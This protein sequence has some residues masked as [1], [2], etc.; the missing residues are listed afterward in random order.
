MSVTLKTKPKSSTWKKCL[1]SSAVLASVQE[2]LNFW[3]VKELDTFEANDKKADVTV[4]VRDEE[5]GKVSEKTFTL[6]RND[7]IVEKK[8]GCSLS[9]VS[10]CFLV[11]S[12]YCFWSNWRSLVLV[13]AVAETKI[14][15]TPSSWVDSWGGPKI[16][17]LRSS[18]FV[19]Q[20]VI[21]GGSASG[22]DLAHSYDSAGNLVLLDFTPDPELD[23]KH[24]A[25][26]MVNRVQKL[27]KEAKLSPQDKV[28]LVAVS[29]GKVNI[30]KDMVNQKEYVNELLRRKLSWVAEKPSGLAVVKSERMELD[31][32]QGLLLRRRGSW[33]FFLCKCNCE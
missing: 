27:C 17:Y 24:L 1:K 28:D 2:K 8:V 29:V 6:D 31:K 5:S 12:S 13:G 25:R 26:E 9:G 15:G 10:C 22:A 32:V 3:T 20:V 21:Q 33:E 23:R 16:I 19:S 11:V 30:E 7:L 18:S 14:I 4:D